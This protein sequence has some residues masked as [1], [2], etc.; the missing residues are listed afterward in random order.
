MAYASQNVHLRTAEYPASRDAEH[1]DSTGPPQK[2]QKVDRR[3]MS[4]V[5]SRKDT[6][7]DSLDILMDWDEE[8]DSRQKTTAAV[9]WQDHQA[10]ML[11]PVHHRFGSQEYQQGSGESDESESDGDVS[12][13]DSA[14]KELDDSEETTAGDDV[15]YT[16][17]VSSFMARWIL[18]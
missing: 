12:D 3:S 13:Q 18:S 2:R 11:S 17:L 8:T 16:Q 14:D 1:D 10:P 9:Y 6:Y 15:L 4:S 5:P 7:D